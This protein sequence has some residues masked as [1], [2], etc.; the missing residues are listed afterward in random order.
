M[1]QVQ[2][3]FFPPNLESRDEV[4]SSGSGNE[5]A[6]GRMKDAAEKSFGTSKVVVEESAKSAGKA[7]GEAMHKTAEKVKGSMSD[8]DESKDEL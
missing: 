2:T 6:G 8:R 4:R 5:G 7:V 1:N 3:E